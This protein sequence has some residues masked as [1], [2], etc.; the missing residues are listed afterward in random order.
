MVFFFNR[1]MGISA[2][3]PERDDIDRILRGLAESI[4]ESRAVRRLL[5]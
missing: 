4:E 5:E 3:D 1:H 2:V